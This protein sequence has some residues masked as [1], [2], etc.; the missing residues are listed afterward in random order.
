ME[1]HATDTDVGPGDR[2]FPDARTAGQAETLFRFSRL[3]E[4]DEDDAAQLDPSILRALAEAM[5]RGGG[6]AS[7]VPAGYTYLGQFVA[8]DLSF[9]RSRPPLGNRVRRTSLVQQRSPRLDL[10]SMY[11]HGPDG[12]PAGPYE[13]DGARLKVGT[14]AGPG[15][16]RGRPGLDLARDGDEA[17]LA[18]IPDRRDDENLAVAQIHLAFIR[19]HNAVVDDLE[20]DRVPGDLFGLARDIVTK[21]YQWL[22]RDDYLTK[23]CRAD[24]IAAVFDHDE[25]KLF[26][27]DAQPDVTPTMPV[28]FSVAAFRFGH[29]MLRTNY[30]W[31][32]VLDGGLVSLDRL[33]DLTGRANEATPEW[34]LPDTAVAD[35]R[36]LFDFGD[37]EKDLNLAMRID[38]ALVGRLSSVPARIVER[39]P[40][41]DGDPR[42]N[43]AYR[44][45]VRAKD[46]RLAS[47]QE[48]VALLRQARVPVTAL[49]AEQ[50][51]V[52]DNGAQLDVLGPATVA[53]IV[54]NT[55][56]WF[57]VLREA[58]VNGGKL[59]HVGAR[60][61]VEVVHRAMEASGASIVRERSWRPQY[62]PGDGTFGMTDLLTVAFGQAHL[63][64][65][66]GP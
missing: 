47:G 19:F 7:D 45:L 14:T 23:V 16:A 5:A 29:S 31:N 66:L 20:A 65:P 24:V 17:P 50:I 13:A 9:E 38:T 52:G 48:M 21:H 46:L 30:R 4:E 12:D 56:L 27:V 18:T 44:D 25:R 64:N 3:R 63:D 36:R 26:E 61:V 57:Y 42:A 35:Y 39:D 33:F 51:A 22:I 43:I 8:H 2:P 34:R 49:S 1:M 54:A 37:N 41:P 58:E 40:L 62:G 32:E 11:G 6:G 15:G 59:G 55:P 28:E 60:I 53:A 10:D